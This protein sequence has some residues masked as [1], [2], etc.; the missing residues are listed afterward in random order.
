MEA[1]LFSIWCHLR[2]VPLWVFG[3][4]VN[5]PLCII[6]PVD[7]ILVA[8]VYVLRNGLVIVLYSYAYEQDVW[9]EAIE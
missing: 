4:R 5:A 8:T 2:L 9:P 6:R 3:T 7:I 1:Y